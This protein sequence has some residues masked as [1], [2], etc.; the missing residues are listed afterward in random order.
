M[1]LGEVVAVDW[2]KVK[3]YHLQRRLAQLQENRLAG[4]G[5]TGVEFPY[6]AE[7]E[8][9]LRAAEVAVLSQTLGDQIDPDDNLHGAPE[10]VVQ[11]AGC[12][13]G[14]RNRLQK[15]MRALRCS[16]LAESTPGTALSWARLANG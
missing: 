10:L 4:F 12:G 2:P 6:W 16:N 7:A 13:C 1:R 11:I 9:D 8:F 3:H 5:Q 14:P 15:R